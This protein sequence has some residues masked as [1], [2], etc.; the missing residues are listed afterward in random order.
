MTKIIFILNKKFIIV[1]IATITN[2]GD[3][4]KVAATFNLLLL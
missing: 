2:T 4:A 1:I 3:A